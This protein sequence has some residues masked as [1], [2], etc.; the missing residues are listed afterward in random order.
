[1]NLAPTVAQI[2]CAIEMC[3]HWS[4]MPRRYDVRSAAPSGRA[5][6]GGGSQGRNPGLNPIALRGEPRRDGAIVAWHEV[7]G[8]APPQRTVP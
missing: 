4:L 6:L 5:A 1:M 7:P 8:T 2:E 3:Y